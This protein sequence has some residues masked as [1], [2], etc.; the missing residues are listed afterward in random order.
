[1][2]RDVYARDGRNGVGQ[3][4]TLVGVEMALAVKGQF[5]DWI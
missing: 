1:L 4:F 2:R 3:P 5:R